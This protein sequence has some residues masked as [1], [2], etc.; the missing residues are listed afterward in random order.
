M[1]ARD[2]DLFTACRESFIARLFFQEAEDETD[3]TRDES[4]DSDDSD[5]TD[6]SQQREFNYNC[7]VKSILAGVVTATAIFMV[8]IMAANRKSNSPENSFISRDGSTSPNSLNHQF[9]VREVNSEGYVQIL[10]VNEEISTYVIQFNPDLNKY[11]NAFLVVNFQ[12]EIETVL[13]VSKSKNDYGTDIEENIILYCAASR[14]QRQFSGSFAK[15]SDIMKSSKISRRVSGSL[16]ELESSYIGAPYLLS[17]FM[18]KIVN[19]SCQ[20]LSQVDMFLW[21]QMDDTLACGDRTVARTDY[22]HCPEHLCENYPGVPI[23]RGL[24]CNKFRSCNYVMA[25]CDPY[26]PHKP[27]S[28]ENRPYCVCRRTA[29]DDGARLECP[30]IDDDGGECEIP[31]RNLMAVQ[32][33]LPCLC[34]YKLRVLYPFLHTPKEQ[35]SDQGLDD[36]ADSN[37]IDWVFRE[38]VIT[39]P[40][41]KFAHCPC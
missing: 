11:Y 27:R 4:D 5:A 22:G 13:I 31:R 25:N 2:H 7:I 19:G 16:V 26:L 10:A 37:I 20:R 15:V 35:G 6:Y 21:N 40:A 32:S 8:V 38:E 24:A 36:T 9:L 33:G 23:S 30:H 39:A 28:F 3:E 29:S 34:M 1:E 14:F 17:R 18:S 12:E 41:L